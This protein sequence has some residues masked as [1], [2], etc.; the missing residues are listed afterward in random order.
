VKY[1]VDIEVLAD[2]EDEAIQEAE[3]IVEAWHEKADYVDFDD[4]QQIT[5]DNYFDEG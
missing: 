2:D 4:I 5:N 1:T 3:K